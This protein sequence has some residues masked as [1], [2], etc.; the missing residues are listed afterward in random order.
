MEGNSSLGVKMPSSSGYVYFANGQT[1][2]IIVPYWRG[3]HTNDK[4]SGS[5]LKVYPTF[6]A[7]EGV[8]KDTER[9]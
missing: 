9:I 8:G 6:V 4:Y 7:W 1:D 5:C 3:D 2:R